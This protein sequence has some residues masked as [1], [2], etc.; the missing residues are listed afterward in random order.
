MR[1]LLYAIALAFMAPIASAEDNI[2]SIKDTEVLATGEKVYMK[3]CSHCHEPGTGPHP[4]TQML[5]VSRGLERAN[6]RENDTLAPEYIAAL[7]RQGIAMMPG[8]RKTEISDEELSA[9]VAFLENEHQEE[10]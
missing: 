5:A 2:K 4:G 6:I 8:F 3:W 9:L 7:V 10:K 1:N